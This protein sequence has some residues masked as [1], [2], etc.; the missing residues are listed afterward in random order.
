MKTTA[1][2]V[3]AAAIAVSASLA[4][5]LSPQAARADERTLPVEEHRLANGLRVLLA[6]DPS[7]DD[8]TVLVRYNVGSSDDP[9]GKEGL[10]HVTQ[11][12]MFDGSPHVAAGQHQ[13]R[14]EE[15]GGTRIEGGTSR[16]DTTFRDTVP[17]GRLPLV[18]WLEA[19]RM[20]LSG[21]ALDAATVQREWKVADAEHDV[22]HHNG[23]AR[24][25]WDALWGEIYPEGH[26]YHRIQAADVGQGVFGLDD[27]RAI[28]RAG[29]GASNAALAIAGPFDPQA[30]F[31]LVERYFGSVPARTPIR[32][33][34]A[35]ESRIPDVRL[36]VSA[37]VAREFVDVAFRAPP[38][39]T[40]QD[41]AMDVLSTILNDTN[42]PLHRELV[43]R[44]IALNA[45]ATEQ[46]KKAG[47][48][49]L[50]SASAPRGGDP[51]ALV[52]TI[53]RIVGDLATTLTPAQLDDAH[54]VRRDA[55]LADFQTS[56]GRAHR[57]LGTGKLDA[58][59]Y[60][61]IDL[62]LL[63]AV[64]REVFVPSRRVVMVVR[65]SPKSPWSGVVARREEHLP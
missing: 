15:V 20:G 18:L 5:W 52:A 29:F 57:V 59:S 13:R 31:A 28:L 26:P 45:G 21:D 42:G 39:G 48:L 7:L 63:R 25:G 23:A 46:S 38:S 10:V 43:E 12:L 53:E 37:S 6:P 3:W 32:R 33:P 8:V 64:A 4:S 27:V 51:E 22:G 16:E 55:L 30:T 11:H 9:P 24:A 56:S 17:P 41:L 1:F 61:A 44:G 14:L 54:R 62:D 47:S 50:L 49:F 40:P 60:D 34:R 36:D 35:S 58:T 65:N 19:D 2:R